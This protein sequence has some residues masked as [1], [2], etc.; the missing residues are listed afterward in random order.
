MPTSA[1][2]EMPAILIPDSRAV[3]L[4]RSRAMILGRAVFNLPSVKGVEIDSCKLEAYLQGREVFLMGYS[5]F[6]CCVIVSMGF[7]S[8]LRHV[9]MRK[10]D[11]DEQR[12]HIF[13][14]LLPRITWLV[15]YRAL[16]E[17]RIFKMLNPRITWLV[18]YRALMQRRIAFAMAFHSRLG[19]RS[20][21]GLR[22]LDGRGGDVLRI[23]IAQSL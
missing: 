8:I 10:V 15:K 13:R 19:E 2:V 7:D 18:K 17:R 12:R 22:M 4:V 9:H 14:M 6:G 3:V 11:E 20:V 1:L 21:V 5:G 16:M 23:I